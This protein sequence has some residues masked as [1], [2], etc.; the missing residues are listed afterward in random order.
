MA[1]I[2]GHECN[3]KECAFIH[4]T[5]R[6]GTCGSGGMVGGCNIYTSDR[7]N[8]GQRAHSII[9]PLRPPDSRDT[10][11]N[12]GNEQ[13][14]GLYTVNWAGLNLLASRVWLQ[15]VPNCVYSESRRNE[16]YHQEGTLL[17]VASLDNQ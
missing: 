1:I 8:L 6:F 3:D 9:H 12:C 7:G 17:H 14:R 10:A 16:R 15:S 2:K 11:I 5:F 13:S 4:S